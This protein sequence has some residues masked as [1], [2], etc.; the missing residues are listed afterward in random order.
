MIMNI[1]F[2]ILIIVLLLYAVIATAA[3]IWYSKEAYHLRLRLRPQRPIGNCVPSSDIEK[4]VEICGA[5]TESTD[6]TRLF[7]EQVYTAKEVLA[8]LSIMDSLNTH[9]FTHYEKDLIIQA[10]TNSAVEVP[11]ALIN[12]LSNYLNMTIIYREK[13]IKNR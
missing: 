1:V 7:G 12:K 13:E 9:V 10:V 6:E 3:C 11:G 5:K 2:S 4:L 8:Q